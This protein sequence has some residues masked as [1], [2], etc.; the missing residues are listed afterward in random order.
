MS[1]NRIE[2][3]ELL[4]GK[5][6][7]LSL[8]GVSLKVYR[9]F[10]ATKN[11][12]YFELRWKIGKK[13]RRR[14]ITD[15]EEAFTE[16]ED[17][18]GR[19]A[20]AKGESTEMPSSTLMYLAE[21]Q[22]K[23][24]DTP[25]HLAVEYYLA[26]HKGVTDC[27]ISKAV[28]EFVESQRGR[29]CSP[30][31]IS[32]IRNHLEP[33]GREFSPRAVSSIHR[34][35]YEGYISR[36]EWAPKTQENFLRSALTFLNFCK[37]K[38]YL[39]KNMP[40]PVADIEP[41]RVKRETPLILTPEELANLFAVCAPRDLAFIAISVFGGGRRAEI[42]RLQYKDIDMEHRIIQLTSEKTKT[43]QRR[44]LEIGDTLAA[45][46]ALIP[47]ND[48]PEALL[49]RLEDPLMDIR[50]KYRER[51][52]EWKQNALRHSFISYHLAEHKNV[53]ATAE[54]A[55]NSPDEI[56]RSY[57]ALVTPKA[58][59]AWFSLTPT[60]VRELALAHNV[61]LAY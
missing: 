1:K 44:T 45:W 61:E 37:K 29:D 6:W 57:K 17:T 34:Q 26:F 43:N 47:A 39:P 53:F 35:E 30:R 31:Y 5:V 48:D 40:T 50:D 56:R 8:K 21:C 49:V 42:Q 10:K 24:G 46:L 60:R 2:T 12:T 41:P 7:K 22:K 3:T 18:I 28:D 19:L 23:L 51:E 27:E 36:N 54:L 55:G 33:F 4:P 14:C 32:T 38:G 13:T 25:M 59:K 52:W 11:Y 15:R 58:A 20:D 16:A 9:I